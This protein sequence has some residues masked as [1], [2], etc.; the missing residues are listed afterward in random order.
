MASV[1]RVVADHPDDPL[2][3]YYPGPHQRAVDAQLPG[4]LARFAASRADELRRWFDRRYQMNEVG[5]CSQIALAVGVVQRAAPGRRL[6]VIDVGRGRGSACTSTGTTST[7][8][9]A[10]RS[11]PRTRPSS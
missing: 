2:A 11:G 7:S 9:P 1:Q 5:R 10:D 4:A 8:A 6:A 3:R